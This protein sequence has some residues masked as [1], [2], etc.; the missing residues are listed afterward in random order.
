MADAVA[1]DRRTASGTRIRCVLGS[2]LTGL[3]VAVLGA[4][5][6]A[7]P[8][9]GAS[10]VSSWPALQ[11]QALEKERR[12]CE[13]GD[14]TSCLAASMRAQS[15]AQRL[16]LLE[17]ACQIAPRGCV[18]LAYALAGGYHRVPLDMARAR[19]M[20][21]RLCGDPSDSV[22]AGGAC[23]V[24][25]QITPHPAQAHDLLLR[26]CRLGWSGFQGYLYTNYWL[27]PGQ[28]TFRTNCRDPRRLGQPRKRPSEERQRPKD[29]P[30]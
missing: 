19:D 3:T 28:P 11:S 14:V 6:S 21:E 26:A 9:G 5:S 16:A 7:D 4:P 10:R 22:D 18:D 13:A 17:R 30:Q 23:L 15:E 20:A 12:E 24:L 2:L 27:P 8:D 25:A 29:S 1:A